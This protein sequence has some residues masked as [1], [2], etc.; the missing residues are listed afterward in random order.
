MKHLLEGKVFYPFPVPAKR[1]VN[2]VPISDSDSEGEEEKKT[3]VL[4][5]AVTHKKIALIVDTNV[6]LKQT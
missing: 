4:E 2:G 3:A 1:M 6:L 5:P